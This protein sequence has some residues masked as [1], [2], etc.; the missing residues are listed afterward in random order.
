MFR[1]QNTCN[2]ISASDPLAP[3][4]QY[5]RPIPPSGVITTMILSLTALQFVFDTP[6]ANYINAL[7]VWC[8]LI[9]VTS[10]VCKGGGYGRAGGG[11]CP[12]ARAIS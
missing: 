9:C 7:Q 2:L 1:R 8:A 5:R 10:C 4:L 12:P 11:A 3:P 6:P